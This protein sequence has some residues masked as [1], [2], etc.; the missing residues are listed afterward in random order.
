MHV[1]LAEYNMI[2]KRSFTVE[3]LN[4]ILI[5]EERHTFRIGKVNKELKGKTN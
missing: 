2:S 1:C 3:Y 5:S 4:P